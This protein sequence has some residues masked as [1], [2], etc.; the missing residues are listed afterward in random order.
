[1]GY[2]IQEGGKGVK[3][4]CCLV[5]TENEGGVK[6]GDSISVGGFWNG[7]EGRER[8]GGPRRTNVG[9]NTWLGGLAILYLDGGWEVGNVLV[10]C[11]K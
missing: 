10:Q 9:W 4:R 6:E 11:W 1:V 8:E 7:D 2:H 5:Q 3:G